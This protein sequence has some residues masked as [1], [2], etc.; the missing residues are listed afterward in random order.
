MSPYG[1]VGY[2]MVCLLA[3]ILSTGHRY[4]ECA[5]ANEYH[6]GFAKERNQGLSCTQTTCKMAGRLCPLS[7]Q[8]RAQTRQTSYFGEAPRTAPRG[9]PFLCSFWQRPLP[10][11]RMCYTRTSFD[12]AKGLQHTSVVRDL[13]H[14]RA[15]KED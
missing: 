1:I 10:C 15:K 7:D 2:V 14:A 9:G 13:Y 5:G 11:P 12:M 6:T 8:K 4:R 3:G